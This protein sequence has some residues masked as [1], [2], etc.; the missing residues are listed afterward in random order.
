L[1]QG[2]GN[3]CAFLAVQEQY[4]GAAPSGAFAG[5]RSESWGD[6]T[7][8]SAAGA[9]GWHATAAAQA[10]QQQAV[11]IE[12]GRLAQSHPGWWRW[13]EGARQVPF[14]AAAYFG[15]SFKYRYMSASILSFKADRQNV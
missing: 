2:E 14:E 4:S 15:V 5:Q 10:Q 7:H 11:L 13:W 9:A 1:L 12:H 3:C 8:A 6:E